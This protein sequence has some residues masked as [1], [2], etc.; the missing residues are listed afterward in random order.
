MKKL[1]YKMI[2]G[3]YFLLIVGIVASPLIYFQVM[4]ATRYNGSQ[5]MREITYFLDS[6][7]KNVAMVQRIHEYL[8][9]FYLSASH[10]TIIQSA[11]EAQTFL[12]DVGDDISKEMAGIIER[13]SQV[14]GLKEYLAP[15]APYIQS[16]GQ[17]EQITFQEEPKE[18]IM[19]YEYHWQSEMLSLLYD[20]KSER[21]IK[22]KY[23]GEKKSELTK[24]KKQKLMGD[25]LEYC[26]LSIIDDWY[27][28]GESMISEK[29]H[30][31]LVMDSDKDGWEL[32]FAL[33]D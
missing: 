7:V 1:R 14:E 8:N 11:N 3:I 27:F 31:K 10:V 12:V 18:D 13:L 23:Q 4:D 5:P 15:L 25:F 16:F 2:Y 6:D 19:E 22:V 9:S 29:A 17:S 24:E 20:S 32:G 28:N 33:Q 21:V 26:N 30:L